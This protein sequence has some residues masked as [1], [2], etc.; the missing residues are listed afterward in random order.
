MTLKEKLIQVAN[1]L[2]KEVERYPRMKTDDVVNMLLTIA[3]QE[4]ETDNELL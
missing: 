4:F 2:K 1:D 3:E